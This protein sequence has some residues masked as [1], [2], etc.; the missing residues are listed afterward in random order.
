VTGRRIVISGI[1]FVHPAGVGSRL[2]DLDFSAPPAPAVHPLD[3]GKRCLHYGI[4]NLTAHRFHPERKSCRHL[5]PDAIYAIVAASLALEDAG[6]DNADRRETA[7][8]CGAGQCYADMW[9]FLKAGIEASLVN[10][11]FDLHR[12]CGGGFARINPFFSVRTL[13]ALPM[14]VIAEKYGIRGENFVC[15]SFGAE[16]V[17]PIRAA[18]A[19][20]ERGRAT[21]ALVGGFVH[22]AN[23]YE[24]GTMYGGRL[25]E[26]DFICA[27]SASFIVLEEA[28]AARSRGGNILATLDFATIAPRPVYECNRIDH[29]EHLFEGVVPPG[30]RPSRLM[31]Q[32]IGL[33]RFRRAEIDA[34]ALL[35][36]GAIVDNSI[37]RCGTLLAGAEPLGTALTA[38][39]LEKGQS[40]VSLSRS[41]SGIDGAVGLSGEDARA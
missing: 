10:G 6:L 22:L 28:E 24:I 38:F 34:A 19:E 11:S 16:S 29:G 32:G 21:T 13:S 36:P 1:G 3:E 9:P 27:S 15:S 40:G 18:M 8:F 20:I 7:L 12:F 26:G 23:P 14:E 31:V 37:S 2:G 41:L 4:P 17:E 30:Y 33:D 39:T 5:R 35:F 25:S